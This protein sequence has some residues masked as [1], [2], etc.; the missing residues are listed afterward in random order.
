MTLKLITTILCIISICCKSEELIVKEK[1]VYS[2]IDR[3][4]FEVTQDS[5]LIRVDTHNMLGNLVSASY[6]LKSVS[7]KYR[8]NSEN[9]LIEITRYKNGELISTDQAIYT[10]DGDLI[11][12]KLLT[13]DGVGSGCAARFVECKYNDQGR[14]RSRI[15]VDQFTGKTILKESYVYTYF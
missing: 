12:F 6:P 9:Y 14:V 2:F 10:E 7:Y 8:Y 13:E 1:Y 15:M 5:V 3:S 4:T 11:P